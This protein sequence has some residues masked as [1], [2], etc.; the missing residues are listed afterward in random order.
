MVRISCRSPSIFK[1]YGRLP[2]FSAVRVIVDR[3]PYNM[4]RV[5]GYVLSFRPNTLIEEMYRVVGRTRMDEGKIWSW[6]ERSR[7]TL[8]KVPRLFSNT[9]DLI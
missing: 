8:G 4:Q 7:R 1:G 3:E 6:I 2:G 5:Y 9:F